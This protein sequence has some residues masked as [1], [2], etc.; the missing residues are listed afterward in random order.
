[1]SANSSNNNLEI[2]K[3]NNLTQTENHNFDQE[4]KFH[5][6]DSQNQEN[7]NEMNNENPI[8]A[9]EYI[10]PNK[11]KDETSIVNSNI[12]TELE[13][14]I[15]T[16]FESEKHNSNHYNDENIIEN[17]ESND[18]N[19]NEDDDD[20]DDDE[21][22]PKIIAYYNKWKKF[23]ETNNHDDEDLLNRSK[24][25]NSNNNTFSK[26]LESSLNDLDEMISRVDNGIKLKKKINT[27]VR[28][29]D[30]QVKVNRTANNNE[31]SIIDVESLKKEWSSMFNKLEEEYKIKLEE[32]QKLNDE[33]LKL[34]GEDIK[35]SIFEHQDKLNQQQSLHQ[36]M[37]SNLKSSLES[38]SEQSNNLLPGLSSFNSA[39]L[40]VDNAK[41]ISNL[42]LEL[43]T[44]HD[45]HVQ[46]LKNYYEKE[47]E[48]LNKKLDYYKSI[49]NENELS[50]S[51]SN[52]STQ[53]LEEL[54]SSARLYENLAKTNEDYLKLN[55]DLNEANKKL[56]DKLVFF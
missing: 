31:S 49:A 44:K 2:E 40:V 36:E 8:I 52:F 9:F 47:I 33:K 1:M 54:E 24:K 7:D 12:D 18:D 5:F 20:D 4:K 34:L 29:Y 26:S 28:E 42:R 23:E 22:I 13:G 46:D 41:Y 50:I 14:A 15:A 3:S 25:S 51:R 27:G 6:I 56:L 55:S 17:Q 37:Q 30:D 48:D 16:S 53:N 45:R 35:K 38:S 32:Q 10:N 39:S 11:N 19:N 43:K 21:D